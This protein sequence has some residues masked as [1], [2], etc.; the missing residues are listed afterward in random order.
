MDS[1]PLYEID[2]V[3]RDAAKFLLGFVA[4]GTGDT[5][6]AE[7][8]ARALASESGEA[9]QMERALNTLQRNSET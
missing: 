9:L 6:E 8:L 5:Q 3:L 1:P 7:R 2:V 4:N